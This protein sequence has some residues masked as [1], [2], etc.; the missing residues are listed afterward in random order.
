MKTYI[1][2]MNVDEELAEDAALALNG[3][4]FTLSNKWS[5]LLAQVSEFLSNKGFP[6]GI[7]VEFS[8]VSEYFAHNLLSENWPYR[9]GNVFA[10]SV[11]VNEPEINKG[12]ADLLHLLTE[13]VCVESNFGL[14]VDYLTGKDLQWLYSR[15]KDE[16]N[17]WLA[18]SRT[19]LFELL[20]SDRNV[21]DIVTVSWPKMNWVNIL[22][23]TEETA[24]LTNQLFF[25]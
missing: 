23:S 8:E 18:E 3:Q 17:L 24:N 6:L 1:I 7:A 2:S 20:E 15:N 19:D 25:N 11:T 16:I 12:C 13:K 14:Y 22:N 21:A 5:N 9:D 4:V 10:A